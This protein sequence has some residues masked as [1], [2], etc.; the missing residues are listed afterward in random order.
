MPRSQWIGSLPNT[1]KSSQST[2]WLQSSRWSLTETEK[3]AFKCLSVLGDIPW[4]SESVAFKYLKV[5]PMYEA[6][7]LPHVKLKIWQE[8]RVSGNTSLN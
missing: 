4:C 6:L 2:K 3:V 1:L 8:R 7:Q 5:L